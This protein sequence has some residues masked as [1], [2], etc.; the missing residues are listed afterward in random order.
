[1]GLDIKLESTCHHQ[2]MTRAWPC[3]EDMAM[4]Q[5]GRDLLYARLNQDQYDFDT[6][7]WEYPMMCSFRV[8]TDPTKDMDVR[9]WPGP[10]TWG[11]GGEYYWGCFV[12]KG[13]PAT[14]GHTVVCRK[15]PEPD[16]RS[17]EAVPASLDEL[18]KGLQF[19]CNPDFDVEVRIEVY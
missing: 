18:M 3:N 16:S 1:V 7:N 2:T 8:H 6:E 12:T 13:N 14:R 5:H 11:R 15:Y 4:W 19:V 10:C 17:V 9:V